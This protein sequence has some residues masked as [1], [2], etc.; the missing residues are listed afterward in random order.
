MYIQATVA[1]NSA[2]QRLLWQ[3]RKITFIDCLAK[4]QI[5]IDKVSSFAL[6]ILTEPEVK[7]VR[8]GIKT[9]VLK[10]LFESAGIALQHIESFLL[11]DRDNSED[12]SVMT[13]VEF[14]FHPPKFRGVEAD[15]DTVMAGAVG[16]VGFVVSA[17]RPPAF[18]VTVGVTCGMRPST[19]LTVPG[20]KF[21][22][23]AL[24]L[25]VIEAVTR[26]VLLARV[27]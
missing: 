11:V 4:Q 18:A 19:S 22:A 16:I 20:I 27:D 3:H 2:G 12:T 14:Y 26:F 21:M 17:G 10:G 9:G 23:G 7:A 25:P 1:I 8:S 15:L 5:K 24:A 13:N 6:S